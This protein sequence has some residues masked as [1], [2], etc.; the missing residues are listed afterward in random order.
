MAALRVPV[1]P[2]AVDLVVRDVVGPVGL[3]GRVHPAEQ[4]GSAVP[5]AALKPLRVVVVQV[6]QILR[7][8]LVVAVAVRADV[9]VELPRPRQD[10]ASLRTAST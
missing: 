2:V 7:A 4:V 3:A 6:V 5:V 8:G 1:D 10:R 9:A